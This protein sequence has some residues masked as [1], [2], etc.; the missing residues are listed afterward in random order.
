MQYRELGNH[1]AVA[2]EAAQEAGQILL[3]NFGTIRDDDVKFKSIFDYVTHIDLES[4]SAIIHRIKE[5]FPNHSILAEESGEGIS[6]SDYVWIIDPLDGTTNFIHG[7][8]FFSV[9][10]G[11]MHKNEMLSGVIYDPSREELFCAQR[12][13]G[14]FLNG[15]R[16]SISK[17]CDLSRALIATGFPFRKKAALEAYL[18][19]FHSIF[20]QCS[21]I[22]RAGS[23]ALDLAYVACGRT[24]GFWELNLNIWDTAAG[25]LIISEAGGVVS[26]LNGGNEYLAT[27]NIVA[28]NLKIHRQLVEITSTTLSQI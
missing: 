9:S 10:I 27:G 18:K 12:G 15:N 7:F 11:L 17:T 1:M 14:A 21:G 20:A 23:A 25:I 22:R 4:E 26:D 13:Q 5:A 2:V 16:I 24:E 6:G 28:G 8:P 3:N 19:S